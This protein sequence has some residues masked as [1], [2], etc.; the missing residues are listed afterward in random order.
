MG[1][2]HAYWKEVGRVEYTTVSDDE[3]LDAFR[4]L[5]ELEGIIPAME[6]A[7][8]VATAVEVAGQMQ[9]DAILLV[10]LSGRGDKDVQEAARLLGEKAKGTRDEGRGTRKKS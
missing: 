9:A 6:T 4:R 8:A 5:A 2:E 1:P 10:C 3:A 7:H